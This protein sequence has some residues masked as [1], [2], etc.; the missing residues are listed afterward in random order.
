MHLPATAVAYRRP[1]HVGAVLGHGIKLMRVVRAVILSGVVGSWRHA[2]ELGRRRSYN[3]LQCIGLCLGR[4][5]Y[6]VQVGGD[7]CAMDASSIITV[8]AIV[9]LRPTF[10]AINVRLVLQKLRWVILIEGV[11]GT[12][13][14]RCCPL[15][16]S[17][18]ND[19]ILVKSAVASLRARVLESCSRLP[20]VCVRSILTRLVVVSAV[21]ACVCT[22]LRYPYG[23]SRRTQ[24]CPRRGHIIS[25][26]EACGRLL[27]ALWWL[28]RS[29]SMNE[30]Y[31]WLLGL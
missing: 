2:V 4:H 8:C 9:L 7:P 21:R 14:D 25:S 17:Q 5:M 27:V 30:M 11:R 19:E 31:P 24:V 26:L 10:S 28:G 22:S 23:F 12:Y 20:V 6:H 13:A 15:S 29:R 3:R 18:R 1:F 16:G